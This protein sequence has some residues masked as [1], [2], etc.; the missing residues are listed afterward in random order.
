MPMDDGYVIPALG[1][2]WSF[3][4]ARVMEW[5]AG[6]VSAMLCSELLTNPIRS[7]PILLVVAVGIPL[8]LAGLRKQFP[9][10]ERGLRNA[11]M[12]A[13]GFEPPGIPK[14][15]PMQPIWSGAPTLSLPDNCEF[16]TLGLDAVFVD[17]DW[18]D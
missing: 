2:G 13:L 10:E 7:M 18:E 9:D 16:L 11:A 1:E 17:Q 4:G 14:P 5:V 8:L 12:V 6:L 15:A 3:A